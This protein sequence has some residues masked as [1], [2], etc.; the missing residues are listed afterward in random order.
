M[1]KGMGI[2]YRCGR[3]QKGTRIEWLPDLERGS[4]ASDLNLEEHKR[5]AHFRG[6]RNVQIKATRARPK[7]TIPGTN[8]PL[9]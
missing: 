3:L 2:I 4:C 6:L 7:P 1:F 8:C 5:G 9:I